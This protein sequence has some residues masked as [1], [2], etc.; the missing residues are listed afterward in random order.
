MGF[1]LRTLL[2][3]HEKERRGLPRRDTRGARVTLRPERPGRGRDVRIEAVKRGWRRL[4]AVRG[5]ER[6]RGC[7]ALFVTP[8]VTRLEAEGEVARFGRKS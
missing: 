8:F 2:R 6:E 7:T 5:V 4:E 3:K 1:R